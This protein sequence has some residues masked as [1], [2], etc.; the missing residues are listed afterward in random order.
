MT[1]H[2]PFFGCKAGCTGI[3]ERIS[4]KRSPGWQSGERACGSFG[5]AARP[6]SSEGQG[7]GCSD[8]S[9]RLVWLYPRTGVQRA[10]YTAERHSRALFCSALQHFSCLFLFLHGANCRTAVM[11]PDRMIHRCCCC[12][13]TTVPGSCLVADG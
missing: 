5:P 6:Y 13:S 4:V 1:K 7:I 10:N 12:L 11:P 3:W 8:C 9:H 2:L